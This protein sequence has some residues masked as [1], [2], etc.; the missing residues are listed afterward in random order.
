MNENPSGQGSGR[1]QELILDLY[2]CNLEAISSKEKI[3]EFVDKLCPII[4][5]KKYGDIRIERFGGNSDFGDGYSFFQFIETSS[6]SGH[7]IEPS[8]VAF[9]NIFSC[10]PF[11]ADKAIKFSRDFFEAKKFDKKVLT[12]QF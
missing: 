5:M 8:R 12:R 4:A 9:I 7:F 6:I 3:Q 10:K 2:N 1:G 11:D